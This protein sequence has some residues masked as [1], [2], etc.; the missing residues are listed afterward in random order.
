MLRRLRPL[1]RPGREDDP[2]V[3]SRPGG[4]LRSQAG[5]FHVQKS[6][7]QGPQVRPQVRQVR[8]SLRLGR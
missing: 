3:R 2:A 5:G 1:S 7:Q 4:A 8:R 6:L